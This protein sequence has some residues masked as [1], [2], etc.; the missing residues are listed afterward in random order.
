MGRRCLFTARGVKRRCSQ[1]GGE[2]WGGGAEE[3][4]AEDDVGAEAREDVPP[5]GE[6]VLHEGG[7]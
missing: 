1:R 6:P 2:A 4:A 5:D 3:E 7:A